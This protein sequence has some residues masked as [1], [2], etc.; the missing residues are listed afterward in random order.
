MFWYLESKA[1]YILTFRPFQILCGVGW[2]IE[3]FLPTLTGMWWI[4]WRSMECSAFRKQ[5]NSILGQQGSVHSFRQSF[6]IQFGQHSRSNI[7]GKV[8]HCQ[9]NVR[10]LLPRWLWSHFR[11]RCGSA[12]LRS[13]QFQHGFLLQLA[14]L[15]RWRGRFAR[16]FNGRLQFY[17]SRIWNFHSGQVKPFQSFRP[18]PSDSV[19]IFTFFVKGAQI[20]K[21]PSSWLFWNKQNLFPFSILF[22]KEIEIDHVARW[23]PTDGE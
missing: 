22:K 6:P 11:S 13:M 1:R 15:V 12:D 8:R 17:C 23:L 4:Y 19:Q 3:T 9:E 10:H 16:Q 21:V 18:I 20:Q 7:D 14:A 5:C 2:N